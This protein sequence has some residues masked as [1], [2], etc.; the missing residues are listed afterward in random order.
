MKS[1]LVALVCLP[2]FFSLTA[3]RAPAA[4]RYFAHEAAED[5]HGVIAPWYRGLNGQCDFRVRVAAETMKRYPWALHPKT[6]LPAPHYIYNGTWQITPEG[7]ITPNP[8]RDWTNG[9]LSQ[10]CAYAMLGFISYYRYTGDPA[11][12][13]QISMMNDVILNHALTGPDHPWPRFLISCP[14][15][16]E[17][18]G[19]ANPHGLIQL[20][21]VGLYGLALVQAYELTGNREWFEA[22]THWADLLAAKRSREPG[23]P[24]WNRYAS[25]EDVFW[26][27]LQT[28]GVVMLLRFFDE[29]IRAGHTGPDRS[30]VQARAA[31]CAYLRDA[32]LPRWLANDTWGRDY[33]D[34]EHAV[35]GE[36]F[37]AMV[38]QYLM[39]HPDWFPNWQTDSRNIMT[40]YLHRSC[41]SPKSNGDVY[42]GAW[43]YPEGCACCGRS[44]DYAPMQVG[45]A[46]AEFGVRANSE[47]AREMARRQFILST[48]DFQDTGVVEDDMDGGQA[49]AGGWFQCAHALPLKYVLDGI[50][51]LPAELGANRENHIVRSRAIVNHVVYARGRIAYSTFDAPQDTV[52]VLRLAFRPTRVTAGGRALKERAALE[53]N[54]YVV[55]PLPNGD[56]LVSLR[57]DGHTRVVVEGD[58]PQQCLAESA[59]RFDG[60]WSAGGTVARHLTSNTGATMSCEFEGNQVRLI[61]SVGPDGGLADVYLDDVK[62]LC[63]IDFWNPYRRSQQVVFYR[64][65]LSNGKHT[66]RVVALGSGNPRSRGANVALE[67]VQ[68]SAATGDAGFGEGGGPTGLQRWIFGYPKREPYVDSAGHAWLPATEVVLRAG[69]AM[70]PVPTN[71]DTLPRR[72]FV[73]GTDDPELYRYGLHGTNFTACF[74]V[75]PGTYHVRVKLMESRAGEPDQ[76]R[77]NIAINGDWVV[78]DLDI[79]ATAAAT[80]P[81]MVLTDAE[82]KKSFQGLNRAV[83]L[84]FDDIKPKN[85]IIAVRFTGVGSAEAIVSA[86]EVGPGPGGQGAKPVAVAGPLKPSAEAASGEGR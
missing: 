44:L 31:G 57:H 45:A 53:A 19:E 38:P 73:K 30:V 6:G 70:D 43:A 39:A 41:V 77:M 66:V 56:C 8:P 20:D 34:W 46:F 65:G 68:F 7:R 72:Q 62:Q 33:W 24:P 1:R 21:M 86:M 48:Y 3:W 78:R 64:S 55:E 49:V 23:A 80:A 14:T 12:I 28:G 2:A 22:A 37:S 83:D 59:L 51:W 85:G 10:R 69:N 75:G 81:P 74:T 27:D 13:A 17:M 61:G 84:V 63:G 50:G 82:R 79:A 40:L 54:G 32:L 16:G 60:Q 35:Q 26:N 67:S 71:W 11:A 4:P 58:D 52:D 25:P 42:S 36:D 15:R 5:R 9:D 47:W 29:V 76:R 18:Y